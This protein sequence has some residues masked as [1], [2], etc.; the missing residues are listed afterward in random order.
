MALLVT[1][2]KGEWRPYEPAP[3]GA[4]RRSGRRGDGIEPAGVCGRALQLPPA[5]RARRLL[6]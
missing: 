1:F 4:E 5:P 2:G 6:P 3:A